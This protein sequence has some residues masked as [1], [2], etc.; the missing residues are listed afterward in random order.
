MPV[1]LSKKHACIREESNKVAFSLQTQLQHITGQEN[2]QVKTPPASLNIVST[3]SKEQLLLSVTHVIS[4]MF[5]EV[6]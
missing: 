2:I 1:V 4:I 5:L 6:F 3:L